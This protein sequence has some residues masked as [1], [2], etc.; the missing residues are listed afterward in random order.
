MGTFFRCKWVCLERRCC[1]NREL[2]TRRREPPGGRAARLA[3][4]WAEDGLSAATARGILTTSVRTASFALS[5]DTGAGELDL[6]PDRAVGAADDN[7]SALGSLEGWGESDA[8]RATG[9]GFIRGPQV[10]G[11]EKLFSV[12]LIVVPPTPLFPGFGALTF[13]GALFVPTFC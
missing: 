1:R 7:H 5:S 11:L 12:A 8:D 6:L 10:V 2:R 4:A 13:F 3:R 9:P